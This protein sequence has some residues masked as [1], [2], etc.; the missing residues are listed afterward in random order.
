MTKDTQPQ[1]EQQH[2]L[3]LDSAALAQRALA[4]AR[5]VRD[6]EDAAAHA[7][8]RVQDVQAGVRTGGRRAGGRG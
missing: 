1:S 2:A 6:I 8:P 5:T 3:F 7:Q 4:A